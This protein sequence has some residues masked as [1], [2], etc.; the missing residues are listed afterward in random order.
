M[1]I[2]TSLNH[3]TVALCP[4]VS[5][6]NFSHNSH[7]EPPQKNKHSSTALLHPKKKEHQHHSIPTF[8]QPLTKNP[9]NKKKLNPSHPHCGWGRNFSPRNCTTFGQVCDH[10]SGLGDDDPARGEWGKSRFST[11][12]PNK[13]HVRS[14]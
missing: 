10:F 1:S 12:T 6:H 8:P 5:M 7:C 4:S 9:L 2:T 11:K 14:E 3:D 13:K